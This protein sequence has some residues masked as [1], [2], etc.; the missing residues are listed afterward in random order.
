MLASRIS[1]KTVAYVGGALFIFF[2]LHSLYV[3]CVACRRA[4]PPLQA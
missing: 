1:E 2:A 4:V 3:G